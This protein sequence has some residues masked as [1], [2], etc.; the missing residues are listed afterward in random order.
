MGFLIL[1]VL[2]IFQ[3]FNGH[4]KFRRKLHLLLALGRSNS[5]RLRT[6]STRPVCEVGRSNGILI[7]V[8]ALPDIHAGIVPRRKFPFG[9]LLPPNAA[10]LG[11]RRDRK[12]HR[13]APF[14]GG[15][16]VEIDVGR[17]AGFGTGVNGLH[18]GLV[19]RGLAILAGWRLRAWIGAWIGAWSRAWS[20]A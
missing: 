7:R 10:R 2:H 16:F 9:P 19:D 12:R 6:P 3:L 18:L 11:A 8:G 14:F 5:M 1:L 17:G 20:R 15:R 13:L 4:R